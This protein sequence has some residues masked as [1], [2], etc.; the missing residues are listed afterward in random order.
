MGTHLPGLTAALFGINTSG[1]SPARLSAAVRGRTAVVTGASRGIGQKL[2]VRLATA[3][4]HVIGVA[5][6]EAPLAALHAK[7]KAAGARFDYLLCD[8]RDTDEARAT[9]ETAIERWGTPALHVA[10]AGHS[11]HRRLT[12]YADRFHDV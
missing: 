3:G 8:L 5:R 11:I 7:A 12:Q 4:A 6:S 10:V 9:A 2:A 1:P